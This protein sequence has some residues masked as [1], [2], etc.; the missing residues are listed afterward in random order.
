MGRG[1][2]DPAVSGDLAEGDGGVSLEVGEGGVPPGDLH[3]PS[4]ELVGVLGLT[5]TPRLPGGRH[6]TDLPRET[7]PQD[8]EPGPRSEHGSPQPI[9]RFAYLPRETPPQDEEPGPGSEHGVPRPS[10]ALVDLAI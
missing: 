9:S 8:E 10:L 6:L 5:P 3:T 4:L 1:L 7:P 2:A